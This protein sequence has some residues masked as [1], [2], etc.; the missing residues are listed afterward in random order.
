M[1][2]FKGVFAYQ[3]EL[4]FMSYLIS[5]AT[6]VKIILK[7]PFT[8]Y[9]CVMEPKV[10]GYRTQHLVPYDQKFS[11]VLVILSLLCWKIQAQILLLCFQ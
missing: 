2:S 8:V 5:F 11:E 6:S 4:V 7:I 10:F 1:E 9:G 3:A